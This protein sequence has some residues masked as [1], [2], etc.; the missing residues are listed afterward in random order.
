MTA[1]ADEAAGELTKRR[2]AP[3]V[4]A[5]WP[6]KCRAEGDAVNAWSEC[7]LIDISILGVG[8]EIV[9]AVPTDLVGRRL[10]VEANA[11][12]GASVALRLIG[13]VRHMS[14][15]AHGGIVVGLEFIDLSET[16]QKILRVME[17]L[18]VAW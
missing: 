15:E 17:V 13:E 18:D 16:E 2:R 1:D 12:V 14:S 9:G 5:G 10:V 11:P 4:S 7:R 6:G 3:R 8:I